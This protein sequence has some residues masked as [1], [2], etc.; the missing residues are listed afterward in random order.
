MK[1]EISYVTTVTEVV[2]VPKEWEFYF[3]KDESEFTDK[4]WNIFDNK[5][6]LNLRYDNIEVERTIEK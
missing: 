2:T 3:K 5:P 6:F 4:E 1:V